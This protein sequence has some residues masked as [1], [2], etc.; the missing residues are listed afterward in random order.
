M[1]VAK[2]TISELLIDP[3]LLRTSRVSVRKKSR[4]LA[5]PGGAEEGQ[6]PAGDNRA[7]ERE[8]G[9]QEG[10]PGAEAVHGLLERELLSLSLSLSLPFTL[11]PSL[12]A[13]IGVFHTYSNDV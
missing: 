13:V 3:R 5:S 9:G 6:Q 12:S 11:S 1:F 4:G 2:L 10:A 7:A 8:Q